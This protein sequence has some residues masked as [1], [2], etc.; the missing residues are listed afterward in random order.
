[1]KGAERGSG[2]GDI[3]QTEY[4]DWK[5]R[6]KSSKSLELDDIMTTHKNFILSL[7]LKKSPQTW[8]C[9]AFITYS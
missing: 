6:E 5:R 7:L 2:S 1:M 9:D 8:L 4:L 3:V